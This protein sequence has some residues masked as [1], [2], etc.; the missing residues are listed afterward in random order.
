MLLKAALIDVFLVI[1]FVCSHRGWN[2]DLRLRRGGA[3]LRSTV[4]HSLITSLWSGWKL[5]GRMRSLRRFSRD[6]DGSVDPG[7]F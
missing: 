4:E 3:K 6:L 2:K 1:G 5:G 7:M